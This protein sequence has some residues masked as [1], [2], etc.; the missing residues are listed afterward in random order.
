M[1]RASWHVHHKAVHHYLGFVV[2]LMANVKAAKCGCMRKEAAVTI[3]FVVR[4]QRANDH[5]FGKRAKQA[6][7]TDVQSLYG[8]ARRRTYKQA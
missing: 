4:A 2:G 1:P 7:R 6:A 8:G 5:R 3:H